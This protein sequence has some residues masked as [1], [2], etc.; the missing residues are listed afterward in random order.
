MMMRFSDD[1]GH[2]W[3]NE[4]RTSIGKLGQRL[5]RAIWRRLGKSR[6]RVYEI[7]ITD[8]V[9]VLIMG[10]ELDVEVGDK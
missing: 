3:S 8:P 1:G 10:A 2:T 7:S 6:D 5:V 9:K 4:K